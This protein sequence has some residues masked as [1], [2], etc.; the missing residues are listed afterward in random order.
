MFP[1]PTYKRGGTNPSKSKPSKNDRAMVSGVS[2]ILRKIKDK[3]NRKEVAGS[4][5]NQFNREG[6]NYNKE[7]FLKNSRS[8]AA[9]GPVKPIYTSNPRDPR[10][11]RYN[12]SLSG[13]RLT[14]AMEP[15]FRVDP[16][17]ETLKRYND[18]AENFVRRTGIKPTRLRTYNGDE[19]NYR[20]VNIE[21]MQEPYLGKFKKPVQPVKYADPKIVEKQKLLKD[22]GLYSG[23]LDGI[24]GSGSKKAWKEYTEKNKPTSSTTS[25]TTA[26]SR[27][28]TTPSTSPKFNIKGIIAD[29]YVPDSKNPNSIDYRYRVET[30]KGFDIIQ[31]KKAF[32]EWKEKNASEY[33]PYYKKSTNA[34]IDYNKGRINEYL[35]KPTLSYKSGGQHGGLDRWF[36]EKWVDVKSGKACGRQKGESR[37]YPACRPSKRIS[38]KTPKTSS[39]LSSQEKARFKSTKTSSQRIPYNH[40]RK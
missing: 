30:D 36:A 39:E 18:Q 15:L 32:D 26:T 11:R 31:G 25:T 14:R 7:K 20:D 23:E 13:Y 24:W 22:A 19:Y 1:K 3:K 35:E 16:M 40:K 21:L 28:T 17:N 33:Q 5:V 27:T 34:P 4:M 9:G 29:Q 8:F 12:D 2:S 37:A 38:S 6:V 10:L